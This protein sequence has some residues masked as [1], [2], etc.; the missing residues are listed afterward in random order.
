MPS[1]AMLQIK[2][3]TFLKAARS[4]W[5]LS[6]I[7]CAAITNIEIANA[8]AASIKVSNRV[9][10]IPRNRN[11]RSRGNASSSAGN[12][13]AISSWRTFIY[14]ESNAA[15]LRIWSVFLTRLT[16]DLSLPTPSFQLQLVTRLPRR[17]LGEWNEWEE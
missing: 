1:T 12:A 9:I 11:P 10:A 16:A 5:M 17:G 3:G 6:G 2:V 15:R 13:D 7:C 14:D 8:N 4:A